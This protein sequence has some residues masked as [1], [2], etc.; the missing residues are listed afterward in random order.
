MEE[1][2]KQTGVDIPENAF[3]ELKDGEK[4]IPV[5]KPEKEYAEVT[6]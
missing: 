5:M 6:P 1:Q 2:K 3:R 4:Y